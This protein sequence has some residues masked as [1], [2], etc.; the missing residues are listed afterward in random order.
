L[1][2]RLNGREAAQRQA[3]KALNQ[4]DGSLSSVADSIA[5]RLRW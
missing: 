4:G 5:T 1:P 3:Q 2:P